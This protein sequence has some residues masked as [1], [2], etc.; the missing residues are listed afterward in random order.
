MSFKGVHLLTWDR[1]QGYSKV[2]PILFKKRAYSSSC[3]PLACAISHGLLSGGKMSH[4]PGFFIL[5]DPLKARF[6][7]WG[8]GEAECPVRFEQQN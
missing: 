5:S 1:V 3:K 2:F 7:A 4:S 6:P 8:G